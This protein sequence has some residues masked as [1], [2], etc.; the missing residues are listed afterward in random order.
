MYNKKRM[1]RRPKKIS[2]HFS[3][4]IHSR[5]AII[6][7]HFCSGYCLRRCFKLNTQSPISNL[8]NF[9]MLCI[10]RAIGRSENS[11]SKG[12]VRQSYPFQMV[13]HY[14]FYIKYLCIYILCTVSLLG[15]SYE[16]IILSQKR[17]E[18][19]LRKEIANISI[20]AIWIE[21]PTYLKLN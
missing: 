13:L 1:W 17:L 12:F 6:E 4:I 10:C 18:C 15:Y 5:S 11:S 9:Y 2:K 7:V 3:S 16:F 8:L 21:R 20:E 14:Y 19:V